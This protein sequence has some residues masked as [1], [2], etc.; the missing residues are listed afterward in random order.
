LVKRLNGVYTAGDVK[1]IVVVMGLD[2]SAAFDA[3]C[4]D[5]LLE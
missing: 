1:K 2:I 5:I 3:I 4:R